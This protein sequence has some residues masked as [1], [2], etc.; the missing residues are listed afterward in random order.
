MAHHKRGRAKRQRAG[1]YC[2]HKEAKN[3]RNARA[4]GSS[5]RELRLLMRKE[6]G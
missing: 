5:G 6:D 1:C 2:G 4:Y 3:A